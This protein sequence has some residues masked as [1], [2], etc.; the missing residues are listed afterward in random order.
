MPSVAPSRLRIVDNKHVHEKHP[1]FSAFVPIPNGRGRHR[2]APFGLGPWD[3]AR[4]ASQQSPILRP[5]QGHYTRHERAGISD[6]TERRLK[7]PRHGSVV[8]S[9]LPWGS[10]R[11]LPLRPTRG[12]TWMRRP[13][14]AMAEVSSTMRWMEWPDGEEF[15][16]DKSASALADDGAELLMAIVSGTSRRNVLG[17]IA[18]EKNDCNFP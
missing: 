7:E 15:A 10:L 6:R 14:P 3:G 17:A 16:P 5:G 2:A 4:V 18:R 11:S 12:A 1:G 9:E 13:G 8:R